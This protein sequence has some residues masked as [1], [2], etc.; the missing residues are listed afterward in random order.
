MST[1]N[2]DTATQG[3]SLVGS[4]LALLSTLYFWLVRSNRE[5]PNID[6]QRLEEMHGSAIL[7][8]EHIDAYRAAG[9]T[10]QQFAACYWLDVVVINNSTLPNAI[11]NLRADVQL[12]SGLWKRAEVAFSDEK[13]LPIN[14][15]PS[16]TDRLALELRL[17]LPGDVGGTTRQDRIDLAHQALGP[18]MPVR[19]RLSGIRETTF[20]FLLLG[21]R[22]SNK[23]EDRSLSDASNNSQPER[24]RAA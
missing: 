9:P 18:E 12:A 24:Q 10:D 7:P 1:L 13:Q 4:A 17:S 20:T 5:R 15:S 11:L 2:F 3:V 19:I 14:L 16:T 22:S 6:I 23:A 21:R 8:Q